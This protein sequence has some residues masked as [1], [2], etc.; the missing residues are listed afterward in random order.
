MQPSY[1]PIAQSQTPEQEI[2]TLNNYQKSLEAEKTSLE[3]EIGGVKA[4]IE[5]LKTTPQQ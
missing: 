3:Q 4:R 2:V 1:Q 5:E